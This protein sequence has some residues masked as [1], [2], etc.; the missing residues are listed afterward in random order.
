MKYVAIFALFALSACQTT[1]DTA[2][3]SG[4]QLATQND[5]NAVIGKTLTFNPGESFVIAANGTMK[6]NWGGAPLVGTYEM[7]D[8]FFCRTLSQGPRGPS[9]EDCQL[10]I[11]NGSSLDVTRD[12]GNG[13]SFSYTVS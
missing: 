7:R 3:M 8:G 13:G 5:L 6:G 2:E 11:L 1:G 4:M 10:L 9:P 12:R